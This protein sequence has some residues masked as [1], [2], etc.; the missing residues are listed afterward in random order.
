MVVTIVTA[1][2]TFSNLVFGHNPVQGAGIGAGFF[3]TGFTYAAIVYLQSERAL[4]P[5]FTRALTTSSVPQRRAIGILPRLILAWTLGSALPL[6]FI[7]AIP[8]RANKGH[9]FPTTV[10]MLFMA[11]GGLVLGGITTLL[12]A[13]SVAEPVEAVRVGMEQVRDGNLDAELAVTTPGDLGEWLA[14]FNE[15]VSGLRER[16]TL[17]DLFGRH[18]GTDVARQA[19]RSGLELGGEVRT[20]T[21]LFVDIIGSTQFAESHPPR[22]VVA[23][24]ND[25]FQVVFDVVSSSGGWINKFEGDGCLCVF[26]APSDLADH[27]ARGLHAA[28]VLG[29][30][31]ATLEMEVG[32]GVSCGEVV[33]GNVGSVQRFEYT[34]IGRPINEAARL[35]E[36]AKEIPGHVLASMRALQAAGPEA[37]QWEPAGALTLRGLSQPL[38]VAVPKAGDGT[39]SDGAASGHLASISDPTPNDGPREL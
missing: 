33:A 13:R 38:P 25:L 20:V 32:I 8:L 5:L 22:T 36:A 17:E 27:P 11:I 31:L 26:G 3:L 28:R 6:L 1:V 4:R 30:R 19:V 9:P 16:R 12:V 37:E 7:I 18:V 39:R 14:G 15:M 21:A 34:V 23:R 10:P 2:I 35:T 29:L 24:V